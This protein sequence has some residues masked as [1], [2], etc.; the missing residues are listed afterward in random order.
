MTLKTCLTSHYPRDHYV[1]TD[2]LIGNFSRTE[3]DI[4]PFFESQLDTCGVDYLTSIFMHTQ[5]ADTYGHFKE[6]RTNESGFVLKA[7]SKIRHLGIFFHDRAEML[8]QILTDYSLSSRS[9]RI[10]ST[11]WTVTILLPKAASAMTFA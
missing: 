9:Y 8:E 2:K 10:S 1:L 4:R 6:C 3:A 11:M 7:E 5:R